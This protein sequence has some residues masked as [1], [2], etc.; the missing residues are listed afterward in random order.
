MA[1]RRAGLENP[2]KLQVCY[3]GDECVL[4]IEG[5]ELMVWDALTVLTRRGIG[6]ACS[7]NISGKP[8]EVT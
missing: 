4:S 8:N 3:L 7:N 1:V 5:T 2:D 6:A